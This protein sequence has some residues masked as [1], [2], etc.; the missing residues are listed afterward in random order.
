MVDNIQIYD[1][2]LAKFTNMKQTVRATRAI[3]MAFACIFATLIM[4]TAPAHAAP[5]MGNETKVG[6]G[7]Q[8]SAYVQNSYPRSTTMPS[9]VQRIYQHAQKVERVGILP[10][11]DAIYLATGLTSVTDSTPT[12]IGGGIT[13][14]RSG[15]MSGEC[16]LMYSKHF[17]RWDILAFNPSISGTD[18][19]Y[20]ITEARLLPDWSIAVTFTSKKQTVRAS[21]LLNQERFVYKNADDEKRIE[22]CIPNVMFGML[23]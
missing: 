16:L 11:G 21:Y 23:N 19:S 5:P 22:G 8:T 9:D 7:P 18:S 2:L 4:T 10:N 14:T 1:I 13:V 20:T 6:C 12:N 3:R 15:Y 17:E